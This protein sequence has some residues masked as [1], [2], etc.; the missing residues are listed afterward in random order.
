[1]QNRY[2]NIDGLRTVAILWVAVYHYCYFWSP[3]GGAETL[4]PYGDALSWVPL[5]QYGE[6]GVYLFFVI[7]AFL[8]TL[9]LQKSQA[10]WQFAARRLIRLWPTLFVCGTLTFAITTALGPE[11]LVRGFGEYAVSLLFIPPN[12]LNVLPSVDDWHWLDGAYWSLWVEVRFYAAV[13]FLYFLSPQRFERNW[14]LFFVLVS[15]AATLPSPVSYVV[16]K[17]LFADYLPFFAMG[18]ALA[19][20]TSGRDTQLSIA[21]F[22]TAI[23]VLILRDFSGDESILSGTGFSYLLVIGLSLYGLLRT[24]PSAVLSSRLFVVLGR[25]SYGYY[26]LHQNAGLALAN[27]F[28][29]V[30]P[31]VLGM[32]LGQALIMAFCVALTL[33]WEEP[34]RAFLS[35]WLLGGKSTAQ[36][37]GQKAGFSKPAM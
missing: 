7:S 11:Q 22:L 8:I 29:E 37:R 36:S 30:M 19:G 2:T 27:A 13:G 9:S 28:A 32:L 35:K 16:S 17:V 14:F 18:I 20:Y 23:A 31:A 25:S 4:L 26:L 10:F 21:M 1:M 15:L 34:M 6:A 24:S 33:L 12:Y 5:A 3:S